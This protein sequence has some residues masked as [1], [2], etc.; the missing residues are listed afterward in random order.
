M[1][2]NNVIYFIQGLENTWK[3]EFLIHKSWGTEKVKC[4]FG[5]DAGY[6]KNPHINTV[7]KAF[8]QMS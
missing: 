6:S 4:E 2:L 1:N 5:A 8:L 7:K 3:I